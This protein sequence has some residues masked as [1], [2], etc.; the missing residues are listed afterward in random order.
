MCMHMGICTQRFEQPTA[1]IPTGSALGAMDE[2]D[3]SQ[4]IKAET[5]LVR[6]KKARE[7]GTFQKEIGMFQKEIMTFRCW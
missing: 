5:K 4:K 6:T 7:I 3:K 2:A 1:V